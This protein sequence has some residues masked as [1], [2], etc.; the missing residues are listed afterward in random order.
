MGISWISN[1]KFTF[2][3]RRS[4]NCLS[5]TAG[6]STLGFARSTR[7]ISH[8]VHGGFRTEYTED[9]ARST[10]RFRTKYTED[11]ARST[12]RISHRV[13]GG[14]VRSIVWCPMLYALCPIHFPRGRIFADSPDIPGIL[15]KRQ[16]G[17]YFGQIRSLEVWVRRL[18][19]EIDP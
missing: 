11:F 5:N 15:T 4:S 6:G 18:F 3:R 16:S 7:R 13:H 8:G 1:H 12:R 17:A 14:F 2:A 9:F 10:R 19:F